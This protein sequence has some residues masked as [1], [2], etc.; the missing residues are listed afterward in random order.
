MGD[1]CPSPHHQRGERRPDGG[2]MAPHRR[3]L[4]LEDDGIGGLVP[5]PGAG[6]QVKGRLFGA[7]YVPR[8]GGTGVGYWELWS[9]G[10]D[11][12]LFNNWWICADGW[13][14]I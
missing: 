7:L 5:S 3:L 8:A 11:P 4:F 1:R 14:H 12:P 2:L 13:P 10:W 9:L 6:S